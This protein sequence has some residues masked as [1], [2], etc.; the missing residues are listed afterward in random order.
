M[1]NA[2]AAKKTAAEATATTEKAARNYEAA[3]I[4]A[5]RTDIAIPATAGRSNRGG[6]SL[7]PFDDLEVNGSFAV[8]NKTAKQMASTVSGAN[9]RHMVDATDTVGNKIFKTQDVKQADGSIVKQPTLETEKVPG[10]IFV[11]ADVDPNTDPD[12][13]V[14]RVWRKQ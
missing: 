4:A 7:Y 3:K 11:V 14:C 10:R 9:K 13:A 6:R 2:P 12:K 5:P 1:A 8:L